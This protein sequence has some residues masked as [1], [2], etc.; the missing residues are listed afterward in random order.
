MS[1]L[2]DR[3]LPPGYPFQPQLETTPREVREK[4]ASDAV[5]LID[6]R[7]PAEAAAAKIAGAVLIPLDQLAGQVNW[8]EDQA[9]ER[10][11]VVHC[12]MG[13]RS[14]KAA[15]FLRSRGIEAFSMAGGIDLWSLDIDSR[16]AR[17]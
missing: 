14:M 6:C 12:H 1:A 15:V 10:P 4:L 8:I 2:D 5:L 9:G 11:V 16:I 3:G 17:Y 13:G 7:T